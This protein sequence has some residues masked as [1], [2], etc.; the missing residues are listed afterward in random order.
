ML[1]SGISHTPSFVL[2]FLYI[3]RRTSGGV[4][5]KRSPSGFR[6]VSWAV[7]IQAVSLPLSS[8]VRGSPPSL[9]TA[10]SNLQRENN[11]FDFIADRS[12]LKWLWIAQPPPFWCLSGV[13][14]VLTGFS[15]VYATSSG[16]LQLGIRFTRGCLISAL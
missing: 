1:I 9:T 3:Y 5:A 16:L 11:H 12:C 2:D 14:L 15:V 8:G 4:W 7:Y 13:F 10:D 6:S